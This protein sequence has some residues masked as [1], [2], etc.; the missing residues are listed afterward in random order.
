MTCPHCGADAVQ[1]RRDVLRIRCAN[2][3]LMVFAE[4]NDETDAMLI[5]RFDRQSWTAPPRHINK[6]RDMF[7]FLIVLMISVAMFAIARSAL[8]LDVDEDDDA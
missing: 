3:H 6:D 8:S 5:A 1:I 2:C 7:F 4:T